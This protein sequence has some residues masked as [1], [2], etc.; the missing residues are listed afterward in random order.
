M[1]THVLSLPLSEFAEIIGGVRTHV[2]RRDGVLYV[3][4]D[5]LRVKELCV[6]NAKP[7]G[8]EAFGLVTCVSQ[9]PALDAVVMSVRWVAF[10]GERP[11]V[12][13]RVFQDQEQCRLCACRTQNGSK[14]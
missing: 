2:V 4:E 6:L 12:V 3:A 14:Q 11:S 10:T 5:M 8:R 7:T 13:V 9:E 1:A